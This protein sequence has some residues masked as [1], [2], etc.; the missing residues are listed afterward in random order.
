MYHLF[1]VYHPQRNIIIDYLK[2]NKIETRIIYEYPINKMKAYNK[3]NLKNNCLNALT[4]SKGIFSLPLYPNLKEK[5]VLF[6]CK[7]IKEC[8]KFYNI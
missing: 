8:L 2:K 6:I 7:K 1:T 4:K 5:N 3:N